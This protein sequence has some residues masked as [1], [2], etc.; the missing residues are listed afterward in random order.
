MII[1][2]QWYLGCLIL[3]ITWQVHAIINARRIVTHRLQI[4]KHSACL[5]LAVETCRITTIMI[6]L[7]QFVSL[8]FEL[9]RCL[10]QK[11]LIFN[12]IRS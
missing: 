2:A 4:L 10:L 1:L 6:K 5:D 11:M 3:E 8:V 12:G 9:R 7:V